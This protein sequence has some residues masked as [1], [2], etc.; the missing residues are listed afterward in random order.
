MLRQL[1]TMDIEISDEWVTFTD[2][3]STYLQCRKCRR[4]GL[5]TWSH[6]CDGSTWYFSLDAAKAVHARQL[7]NSYKMRYLSSTTP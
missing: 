6:V 2:G 3:T 7:K 1:L 4:Y 5:K